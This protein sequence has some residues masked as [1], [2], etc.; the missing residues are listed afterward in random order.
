MAAPPKFR[1]NRFFPLPAGR[2]APAGPKPKMRLA[3]HSGWQA[4]AVKASA[5][6]GT[7]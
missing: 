3:A 4:R 7:Q 1:P 6:R 2:S 5:L